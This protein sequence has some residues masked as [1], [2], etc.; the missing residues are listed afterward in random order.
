MSVFR[1]NYQKKNK[2]TGNREFPVFAASTT[3]E[4]VLFEF[5]LSDLCEVN[6]YTHYWWQMLNEHIFIKRVNVKGLRCEYIIIL[7]DMYHRSKVVAEYQVNIECFENDKSVDIFE[8][9][10]NFKDLPNYKLPKDKL[11]TEWYTK[12]SGAIR[13]FLFSLKE[14]GSL[15]KLKESEFM[16]K[17]TYH[18]NLKIC[19]E[20]GY[21]KEGKLAKRILVSKLEK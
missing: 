21:I 12:E 17:A 9:K 2:P 18:R 7:C 13:R 16:S 15:K 14:L 19:I 20:K 4:D 10:Q 8:Q 3:F 1:V 6:Y 5:L 11:P